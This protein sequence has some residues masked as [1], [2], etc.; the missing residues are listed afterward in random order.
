MHEFQ[1][2]SVEC[3]RT[4]FARH[5]STPLLT[6]ALMVGPMR[7]FLRCNHLCLFVPLPAPCVSMWH[8]VDRY[9]TCA[10][11]SAAAGYRARGTCR[12]R[13]CPDRKAKHQWHSHAARKHRE[14]PPPPASK[15]KTKPTHLVMR[16]NLAERFKE[17]R[18]FNRLTRGM[19]DAQ[20]LGHADLVVLR[21]ELEHRRDLQPH[22]H[23]C[24]TAFGTQWRQKRWW[25]APMKAAD[26]P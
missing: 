17:L 19:K 25:L 12:D 26:D 11:A 24:R 2:S 18:L 7:G 3:L 22:K 16:V 15:T 4:T 9:W 20:Q 14:P 1:E 23:S 6:S 13:S 10:P 8:V 5:G 21:K